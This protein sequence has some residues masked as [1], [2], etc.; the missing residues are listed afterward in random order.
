MGEGTGLGLST[1][2]GIVNMHS[3]RLTVQSEPGRG[4]TFSIYLPAFGGPASESQA[5]AKVT[6]GG[7]SGRVLLVEDDDQVRNLTTRLLQIFGYTVKGLENGEKALNWLET[8]QNYDLLITDAVMPGMDGGKL[9]QAV[10][11]KLPNL[12]VLFISGYTDDRLSQFGIHRGEC[13]FLAKPFS[14]AQLQSS[15]AEILKRASTAQPPDS[16]STLLECRPSAE[17]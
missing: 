1:V 10:R 2:D 15:V 17:H 14:P 13:N 4:S 3:G 6:A 5:T 7:N 8:E 9:G 12:P 16:R 11:T